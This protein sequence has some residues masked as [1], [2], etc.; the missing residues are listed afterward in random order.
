MLPLREEKRGAT[1]TRGS[2]ADGADG[3]DGWSSGRGERLLAPSQWGAIQESLKL[4]DRELQITKQVFNDEK[5]ATIARKLGISSHTVHTHLER[6]YRKL[7]VSSRCE[8]LVRIFG[9]HLGGERVGIAEARL[10]RRR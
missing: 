4:S 7:G 1:M 6:L 8:L 10:V 5:E 9:E 2:M 3:A